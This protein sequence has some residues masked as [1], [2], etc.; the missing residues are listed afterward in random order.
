MVRAR[1]KHARHYG[2]IGR[3][4]A[5]CVPAARLAC[6]GHRVHADVA[7]NAAGRAGGGGHRLLA[8]PAV[9]A[10][11]HSVCVLRHSAVGL[12]VSVL[13]V[14]R[15]STSNGVGVRGGRV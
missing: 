7:D 4:A 12:R 8:E 2:Y 3:N 15:V 11:V 5:N 1:A 9:S 14:A 6:A 10:A 13:R